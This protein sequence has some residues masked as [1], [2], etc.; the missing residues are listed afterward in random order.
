MPIVHLE[1]ITETK[2][3]VPVPE[4]LQAL[5]DQLGEL[6]GSPAG[7]TWV[8]AVAIPRDAYAEN[9]GELPGD[10]RPVFAYITRHG[11]PE[12]S[13]LAEE[14]REVAEL[15][16]RVLERPADNMHVIYEPPGRGRVAFGGQFRG[17]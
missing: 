7:G 2:E 5:A 17:S 1:I 10:V 15:L 4:V 14:A 8:K 16:S 12:A 9:G 3:S 13:R 11:L 6:L